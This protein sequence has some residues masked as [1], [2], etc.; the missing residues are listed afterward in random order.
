MLAEGEQA[1]RL[2]ARSAGRKESKAPGG[3]ERERRYGVQG[4]G[5]VSKRLREYIA[6]N[7]KVNVTVLASWLSP[8]Y[9]FVHSLTPGGGLHATIS[10]P[11]LSPARVSPPP[12]IDVA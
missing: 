5:M 8:L 11:I 4:M 3:R 2:S 6:K 12:G 7:E 9:I 10:P 1:V